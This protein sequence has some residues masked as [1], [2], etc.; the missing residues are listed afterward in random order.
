MSV[1]KNRQAIKSILVPRASNSRFAPLVAPYAF[2]S[3]QDIME[4]QC[5]GKVNVPEQPL[6]IDSEFEE[7]LTDA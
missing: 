3:P 1:E 7:E 5:S 2:D 4:H 6:S